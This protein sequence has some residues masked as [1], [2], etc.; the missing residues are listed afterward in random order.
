MQ[1]LKGNKMDRLIDRKDG[2]KQLADLLK[3]YASKSNTIVIGLP[4]GGVITAYEV[5]KQLDLPLDIIITRKIG[6]PFQPE[7][8]VGAMTQN[9]TVLFNSQL[10]LLGISE[11]QLI[12]V[13][14]KERKELKRRLQLYRNNKPPLNLTNKTILLID[15]GI[16]TSATMKAAI[17]TVRELNAHK[18]VVGVPVAPPA[19]ASQL[20]SDIDE[21]VCVITPP[22]FTAIGQFY[23][24]FPQVQD[25]EVISLLKTE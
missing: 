5:A 15:D 18:I 19:I 9:G 23:D 17:Q 4:R 16:A 11:Q 25:E 14:K 20:T 10:H 3:H 1:R 21:Y 13:I 2:G 6:A 12:P 22:F 24:Q 8:A 7:L